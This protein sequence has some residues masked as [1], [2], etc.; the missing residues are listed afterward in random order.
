MPS[1]DFLVLDDHAREVA[2][3]AVQQRFAEVLA[4]P[5][6]LPNGFVGQVLTVGL[7]AVKDL[8]VERMATNGGDLAAAMAP[9]AASTVATKLRLRQPTALFLATEQT[10]TAL[11]KARPFARRTG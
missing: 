3:A 4:R 1:R 2:L 9:L 5:D 10:L 6:R 7:S 11:R 8:W